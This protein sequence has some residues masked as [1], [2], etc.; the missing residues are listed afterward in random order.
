MKNSLS[1]FER[2][3][4]NTFFSSHLGRNWEEIGRKKY[5]EKSSKIIKRKI[6]GGTVNE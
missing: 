3:W 1:P 5:K 6:C 2:T 4:H